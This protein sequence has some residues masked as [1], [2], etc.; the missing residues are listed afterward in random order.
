MAESTIRRLETGEHKEPS[1]RVRR[2]LARKLGVSPSK[3]FKVGK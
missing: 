3:L 1:D 2:A